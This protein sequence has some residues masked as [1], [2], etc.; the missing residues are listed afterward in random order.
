MSGDITCVIPT[1]DRP[2]LL[3]EAL[4]SVVAQDSPPD[5]VIVV[6][7]HDDD[8]TER[9]VNEVT[10]ASGLT[11]TYLRRDG[12]PGP[13]ASRN[14]GA[15]ASTTEFLAFLDDDDLW[16]PGYL[17]SALTN[18]GD[19]DA[20]ATAFYRFSESG[21]LD[22]SVPRHDMTAE[23]AFATGPGVTGSTLVIR[24]STFASVGG[25]DPALPALNDTDFFVRFLLAGHSYSVVDTPLVGVRKHTGTQL[26]DNTTVRVQR[27]WAFVSKHEANFG[28]RAR[29]QRHFAQYR[30]QW[31]IPGAPVRLR[32]QALAGMAWNWF[33]ARWP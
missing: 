6:S 11:V 12:E 30:M 13:S 33:V 31:R 20:V 19:R 25:Y 26:T 27:G 5:Y 4:A 18:I 9:V 2:D 32:A 16:D 10:A 8:E 23:H 7:D 15:S 3:R 1:H 29:G 28:R 14:H 17:A 21:V 22:T 24:A